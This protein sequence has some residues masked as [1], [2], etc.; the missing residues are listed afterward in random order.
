MSEWSEATWADVTGCAAA[1]GRDAFVASTTATGEPH[2]AIVWLVVVG[3]VFHFVGD[4]GSVKVRNLAARPAVAAHWQVP[5][6]G[7]CARCQLYLRGSASLVDEPAERRRLWD[8]GAWGDLGQWYGGPDDASM[9][10]VRIDT[11][12]ASLTEDAGS[13]PRRR[14]RA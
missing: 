3:D 10:F 4:R 12:Y 9:A 2:L 13:G 6:S 7:A 5:D 1:L 8:S 14:W 11:T